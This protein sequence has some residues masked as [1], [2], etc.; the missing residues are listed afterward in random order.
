MK[1]DVREEG[2]VTVVRLSGDLDTTNGPRLTEELDRLWTK[3][4]RQFV[5]DLEGV[6][7]IYSGGLSTLVRLFKRVRGQACELP[8]VRGGRLH[9]S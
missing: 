6:P 2:K 9:D 8:G 5:L 4:G 3:G 1:I 7:F